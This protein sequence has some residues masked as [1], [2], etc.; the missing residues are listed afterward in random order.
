VQLWRMHRAQ[1]KAI[2]PRQKFRAIYPRSYNPSFGL[3]CCVLGVVFASTF[4]VIFP[5]IGPP[6]VL[7]VLLTMV[8]QRY[9]AHY[10]YGRIGQGQTGGLLHIW[11]IH[12]FATLVALQP[13]L[14]G[15]ILL[16]RLQWVLS[17]ILLG[18]ALLIVVCVETYARHRLRSYSRSRLNQNARNALQHFESV[19]RPRGLPRFLNGNGVG[20]LTPASSS[21]RRPRT[22]IASVLDMISLTLAIM[23]SSTRVRGPLPLETEGIDDLASADRAAK[24]RPGAPP[25]L[26]FT[27]RALE[28]AGMLYPPELLAPT[29]VVW[30]PNDANGVGRQEAYDLQRYHGLEVTL[31]AVYNDPRR[32]STDSRRHTPSLP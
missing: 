6:I 3:G 17:G 23:P 21:T 12:R 30:L 14:L 28:T 22:S 8:A 10:V 25:R 20:V 9:L 16:S 26:A 19:A 5:L 2:T 15:L 13:L 7:L 32:Q 24:T 1:K 4:S 18:T 31:D 27:D 29:P 11:L